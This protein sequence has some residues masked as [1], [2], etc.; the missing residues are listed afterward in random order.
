MF[1]VFLGAGGILPSSLS[2]RGPIEVN[3]LVCSRSSVLMALSG[4]ENAK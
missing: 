1:A 2:W 4:E 3:E